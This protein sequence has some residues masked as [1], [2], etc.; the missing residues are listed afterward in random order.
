MEDEE[1]E[2]EEVVAAAGGGA[3]ATQDE[4]RRWVKKQRPTGMRNKSNKHVKMRNK[5]RNNLEC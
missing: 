2:E 5:K 3:V 4:R 1:E